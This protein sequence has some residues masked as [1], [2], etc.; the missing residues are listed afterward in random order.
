MSAPELSYRERNAMSA[1]PCAGR[2]Y[3]G[4]P[5]EVVEVSGIVHPEEKTRNTVKIGNT[6]RI[7]GVILIWCIFWDSTR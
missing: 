1:E 3:P 4:T 5:V 2:V 7:S 6:T